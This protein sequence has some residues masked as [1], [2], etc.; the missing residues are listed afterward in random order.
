MPAELQ[1]PGAILRKGH[2]GAARRRVEAEDGFVE[3][4][5]WRPLSSLNYPVGGLDRW[6]RQR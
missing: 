4:I 1:A 5:K 2:P 6:F 3:L